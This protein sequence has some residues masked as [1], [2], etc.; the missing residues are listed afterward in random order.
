MR[1]VTRYQE[2]CLDVKYMFLSSDL[3]NMINR[4][5]VI[6]KAIKS[7]ICREHMRLITR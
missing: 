2:N 6:N 7:M 1:I 4:V 5:T 3:F